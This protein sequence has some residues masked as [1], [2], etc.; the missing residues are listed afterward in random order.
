LLA[1]LPAVDAA[2]KST[3]T[4][5]TVVGIDTRGSHELR[6]SIEEFLHLTNSPAYRELSW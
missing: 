3:I 2:L 4:K 6:A 1:G 5:A